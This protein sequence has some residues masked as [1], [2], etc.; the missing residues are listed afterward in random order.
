MRAGLLAMLLY[1]A[2]IT[3]VP[4]AYAAGPLTSTII[5]VGA[6]DYDGFCFIDTAHNA[7]TGCSNKNGFYIPNGGS[8]TD[9]QMC[10]AMI[11]AFM[12]G[13]SV[14]IWYENAICVQNR[15]MIRLFSMTN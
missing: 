1:I 5:A 10:A 8:A 7:S 6:D 3:W 11:S 15:S 12:T 13:K 14:M 9:D 4:T 2:L